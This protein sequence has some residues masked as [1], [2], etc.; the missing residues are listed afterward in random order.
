MLNL[1]LLDIIIKT[2]ILKIENKKKIKNVIFNSKI[3]AAINKIKA[4]PNPAYFWTPYMQFKWHP[5]MHFIVGWENEHILWLK[6]WKTVHFT[7][8][9][10][11]VQFLNGHPLTLNVQVWSV[12]LD[13]ALIANVPSASRRCCASP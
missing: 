6:E 11:N 10:S 8:Q 2:V 12:D 5:K 7:G 1:I 3:W 9:D 4:N 13:L